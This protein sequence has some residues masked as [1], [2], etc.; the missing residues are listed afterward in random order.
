MGLLSDL[1]LWFLFLAFV[2]CIVYLT[3]V[4]STGNFCHRLMYFSA[5]S[6]DALFLVCNMRNDAELLVFMF[7]VYGESRLCG[8][9]LHEE[10]RLFAGT[11]HKESRLCGDTLH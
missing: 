1:G 11:V 9:S 4:F 10:S 2:H 6:A 7:C 8:D 5:C 3:C